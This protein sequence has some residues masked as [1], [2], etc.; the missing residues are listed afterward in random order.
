MPGM[1]IDADIIIDKV[2][3]AL[4]IPSECLN[5]G[6]TVYV[7]GVKVEENDDA[8]E[9]YR[10]VKVETGITNG[11]FVEIISGLSE[12]EIVRGKEI[13]GSNAIMEMMEEM[14]GSMKSGEMPHGNMSGPPAGM[15]K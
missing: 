6:N 9:G 13:V 15:R 11:S 8:P 1:N 14:E 2:E 5:R 12:G 4:M 7:K 3:N 10:T